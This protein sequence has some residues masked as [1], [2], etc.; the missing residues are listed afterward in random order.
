[1]YLTKSPEKEFRGFLSLN[2]FK[3]LF[4]NLPQKNL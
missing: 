2:A 3:G 1:M 4:F